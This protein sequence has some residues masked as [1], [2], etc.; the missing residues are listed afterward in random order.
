MF[1]KKVVP[2]Y[3]KTTLCMPNG[4]VIKTARSRLNALLRFL[5]SHLLCQFK[6]LVD[7]IV[8]DNPS[9]KFRFTIIYNLLS[10]AFNSRIFVCTYASPSLPAASSCYLY[11]SANWLER[12]AWDLHGVFFVNHPDLRKILTD[13]GFNDHPL[14]KDFPISGYKEISYSEKEK[15]VLQSSVEIAQEYR[16]FYFKTR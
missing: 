4:M 8:Y 10:V 14:R 9:A 6:S 11:A 7:I 5:H 15:R 16:V 12:E 13:Y 3:I 1:L 2:S